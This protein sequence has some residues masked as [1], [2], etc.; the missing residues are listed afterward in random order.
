DF[1]VTFEPMDNGQLSVTRRVYAPGLS[2]PIV[3]QSVYQ[4]TS[5]AARFDIYNPQAYPP[6]YPTSSANFIVPDGARVVGVLNDMLSTKTAAVGDRFSLRVTEPA[7]FRDAVIEGHVSSVQR[8]GRLTGRSM[9]TLN[10]DT[11]RLRNG[12]TYRFAG[13][14]E[15]A[16]A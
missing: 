5:E 6:S 16:H 2:Q 4:K 12:G 11:I 7:E 8:S 10:F 14:V 9:M 15:S 1:S 3:A 13:L